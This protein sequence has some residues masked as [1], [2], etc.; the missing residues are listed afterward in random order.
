M[1]A[2]GWEQYALIAVVALVLIGIVAILGRKITEIRVRPWS[3]RLRTSE[4]PQP[5]N[6][7]VYVKR[8][9]LKRAFVDVAKKSRTS[10]LDSTVK[11]STIRVRDANEKPPTTPND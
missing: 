4:D 8:S 11:K 10:I 1:E 7:E 5:K 3:F 2:W 6:E 9:R